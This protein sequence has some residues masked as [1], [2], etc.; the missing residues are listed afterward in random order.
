MRVEHF[1]LFV[2]L[3][4]LLQTQILLVL[5]TNKALIP[6]WIR[7]DHFPLYHLRLRISFILASFLLLGYFGSELSVG[8]DCNCSP[9]G[10]FFQQCKEQ[11]D[12]D[13]Q[14]FF[15][16]DFD[17]TLESQFEHSRNLVF[18]HV[19]HQDYCVLAIADRTTLF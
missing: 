11:F 19:S 9:M 14:Y 17:H 13:D 1:D 16:L 12:Y 2:L 4:L 3:Y 10:I 5:R 15:H 18:E 6:F 8:R 7:L